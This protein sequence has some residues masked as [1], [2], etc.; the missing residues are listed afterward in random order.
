[1]GK[2]GTMS[3]HQGSYMLCDILSFLREAGVWEQMPRATTQQ[4][5]IKIVEFACHRHDCNAGEILDGHEAFG[6]CYSCR[7]PAEALKR[8]LCTI[9]RPDGE[10]EDDAEDTDNEEEE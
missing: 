1:M 5:V 4:L 7:R 10:A 3:N 9:C 8:G 6:I 2:E